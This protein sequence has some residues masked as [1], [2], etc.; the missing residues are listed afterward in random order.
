MGP[1][2][3]DIEGHSCKTLK[4]R[5]QEISQ[6]FSRTMEECAAELKRIVG[7][8]AVLTLAKIARPNRSEG[9]V[10]EKSD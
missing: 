1:T 3:R 2:S 7:R 9:R 8:I 6:Q 10:R 5:G 4:C